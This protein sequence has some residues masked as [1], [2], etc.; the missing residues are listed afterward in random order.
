[1]TIKRA[2]HLV[3]GQMWLATSMLSSGWR[4]TAMFL[5]GLGWMIFYLILSKENVEKP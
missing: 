5:L 3:C 1:M 4:G 2:V